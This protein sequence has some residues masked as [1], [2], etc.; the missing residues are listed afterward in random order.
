MFKTGS[1]GPIS[2]IDGSL[3]TAYAFASTGFLGDQ[4]V[5]AR[6]IRA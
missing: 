1:G 6:H 3:G 4:H 5:N 2:A